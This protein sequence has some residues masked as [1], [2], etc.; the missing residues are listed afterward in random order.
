MKLALIS[1]MLLSMITGALAQAE[2]TR[3]LET[4]S[5]KLNPPDTKRGLPLMEA[6]SVRASTREFS[7][8]ELSMQ[9]LSDLAWAA[10]GVNR[11]DS[12]KITAPS[13]MNSQDIDVYYFLKSGVYLYDGLQHAL[14]PV[15][16]GDH[17][18]E[19]QRA[20]PGQAIQPSL[21][22]ALLV[23]VSDMA[24]FKRGAP[25][26]KREWAA[27]DAG[28]VSQN[29]SLFCAAVGLKTVPRASTDKA[30]VQELLKLSDQQYI[31]LNHPVGYAKEQ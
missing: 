26:L 16:D 23:I 1:L 2:T 12:K 27:L 6:L 25:E 7:E 3:P 28:I 8:K 31:L 13:A 29:I 21:P 24:R 17:R 30:K 19:V 15:A 4:Q 20:R 10:N 18:A 9:D 22:P 5:I 11:A 14:K